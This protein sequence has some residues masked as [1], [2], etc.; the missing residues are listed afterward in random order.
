MQAAHET[1]HVLGAWLTGGKV[2]KIV[3]HPLT[4]SRTDVSPNPAPL[5]ELWAG[6]IGGVLIPLALWD[7]AARLFPPLNAWLRFFAGFCLIANGCYLATGLFDPVGDA[8]ELIR[9]GATAWHWGLFA[10]ITV[11]AGFCLWHGLGP[12]F[13]WGPRGKSASWMTAGTTMVTLIVVAAL[14]FWLSPQT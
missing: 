8:S 5:I 12:E 9:H 10:A 14:G 7:V 13:G 6:P 4:I 1:G 2:V 11:P 3:L